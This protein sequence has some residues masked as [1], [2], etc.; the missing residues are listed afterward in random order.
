MLRGRLRIQ[1]ARS[2]FS[3]IAAQLVFAAIGA[4]STGGGDF[5]RLLL[6]STVQ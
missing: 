6:L 3:A 1:L 2:S 5:P 4:A